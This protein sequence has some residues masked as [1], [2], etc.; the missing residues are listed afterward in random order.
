M[1]ELRLE[2]ALAAMQVI[3]QQGIADASYKLGCDEESYQKV[4]GSSPWTV[5]DKYQVVRQLNDLTTGTLQKLG[6]GE[7]M[8]VSSEYQAAVIAMFVHPMNY[9]PACCWLAPTHANADLANFSG[10]SEKQIQIE[11]ANPKKLFALIL[12]IRATKQCDTLQR[13]F[14]ERTRQQLAG[15]NPDE[16]EKTSQNSTS[17]KK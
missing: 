11:K 15:V 2:T 12:E 4:T 7:V 3:I 9:F 14:R 16:K 6:L 17:D 8:E 10:R 13:K 5:D 1:Q